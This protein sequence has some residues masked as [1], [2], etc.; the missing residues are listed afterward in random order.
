MF[1]IVLSAFGM[2]FLAELGD[3]TQLAILALTA[4]SRSPW[5]VLAGAGSALLFSTALA[6]GL[7]CFVFR[8]IPTGWT[9]AFHYA[10]GTLFVL[11]GIWTIW[12]A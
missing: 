4:E 2:V 5:A 1:R 7:G 10:A 6:V 8:A 12:K 11:I 3:K 9:R